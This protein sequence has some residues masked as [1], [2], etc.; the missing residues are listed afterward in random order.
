ML[1]FIKNL[2]TRQFSTDIL[3]AE[4]GQ[5]RLCVQP[6]QTVVVRNVDPF[7]N[8]QD[9]IHRQ[10]EFRD[11]QLEVTFGC[12][13]DDW[14]CFT[15]KV[16]AQGATK[17]Q[18]LVADADGAFQVFG[19]GSDGETLLWDSTQPLG[20]TSGSGSGSNLD[21]VLIDDVTGQVL[22]DDVTGNVLVDS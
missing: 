17:G 12:E 4:G 21:D 18:V 15:G 3:D 6:G 1:M 7:Y 9:K 20:V 14:I 8:N 10:E 5:I 16:D 2:D 19:P 22:V 11:F 13:T